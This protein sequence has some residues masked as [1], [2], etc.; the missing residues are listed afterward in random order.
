MA[1]RID[2]SGASSETIAELHRQAEVCLSDT[3]RLATAADQRATT[4]AGVF[5]AGSVAL[6]AAAVTI[7][8]A[9]GH[10]PALVTAA[11]VAAVILFVAS[12][13]SAWAARPTDFFVA[14]YEPRF[15]APSATDLTWMLRYATEDLQVRIDANREALESSARLL[16]IGLWLA[17]AALPIAILVYAFIS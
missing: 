17:M 13:L 14:G 1:E 6:V 3:L 8:S 12:L 4:M 9:P 15:L 11:L 10:R 7:F 2:L 16:A 5:G